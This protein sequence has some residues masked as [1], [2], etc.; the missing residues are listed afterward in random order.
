MHET[1]WKR[2]STLTVILLVGGLFPAG[3]EAGAQ[4][5]GSGG[6]LQDKFRKTQPK[7][8][9]PPP[10]RLSVMTVADIPLPGPLLGGPLDVDGTRV[11]VPVPGGLLIVEPEPG[12]E[13]TR[14][15]TVLLEDPPRGQQWVVG[16]RKGKRRYRTDP[17]G[18]L[19]AQ[20][21]A[22]DSSRWKPSW[23]LRLPGAT[24]AQPLV[25]GKRVLVGSTDSRIYAVRFRNGHR[26]WAQDYGDRLTLPLALWHGD[27]TVGFFDLV[28][29]VPH[30]GTT[31]LVIDPFDGRTVA[32]YTLPEGGGSLVSSA[33]VLI[34]GRIAVA[35]QR[36]D[37]ADASLLV[38]RLVPAEE[39]AG[40]VGD[41]PYN[42]QAPEDE[43]PPG[44]AEDSTDRPGR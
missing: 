20:R 18:L 30:G 15:P 43:S 6:F 4:N 44:E 25:V 36:Y 16:G 13:A 33:A 27:L 29:A 38:F 42:G 41:V 7:R 9:G 1:L 2:V 5:V 8:K 34:D 28:L 10:P 39:V 23:K 21:R 35:R 11:R 12:A 24:L 40:T 17:T 14:E 37:Q 31:L 3:R 22:S 32:S 26:I 19:L